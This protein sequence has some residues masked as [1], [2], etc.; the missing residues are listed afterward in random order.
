MMVPPKKKIPLLIHGRYPADSAIS[1]PVTGE[2]AP[3][4]SP[5]R[6]RRYTPVPLP[7]GI[8]FAPAYRSRRLRASTVD[9]TVPSSRDR[10]R[11]ESDIQSSAAALRAPRSLLPIPA[12]FPEYESRSPPLRPI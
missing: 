11:A 8:E 7:T 3:Q 1:P 2:S 12:Q 10:R 5:F 9:A 4:S 6:L